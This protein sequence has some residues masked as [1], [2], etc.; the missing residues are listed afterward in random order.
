MLYF[1]D[2]KYTFDKRVYAFLLASMTA[3]FLVI[4]VN[5]HSESYS[6]FLLGNILGMIAGFSSM[7]G[8]KNYSDRNHDECSRIKYEH[9]LC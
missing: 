9:Y 7:K 4:V 1:S 5:I 2:L 3:N 6:W 8:L